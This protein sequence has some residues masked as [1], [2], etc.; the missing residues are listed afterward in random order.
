MSEDAASSRLL[1]TA[2][3]GFKCLLLTVTVVLG[4]GP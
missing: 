1:S 2:P 4:L 3:Y